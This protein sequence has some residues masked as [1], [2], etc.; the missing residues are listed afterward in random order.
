MFSDWI[1]R[2]GFWSLDGLRRGGTVHKNYLDVKERME[3][4]NCNEEELQD[5]LGYAVSTVPFFEKCDPKEIRSFP[6]I[7]KNDL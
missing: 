4:E 1:R 3:K 2:V 5:L 6:V 7:T